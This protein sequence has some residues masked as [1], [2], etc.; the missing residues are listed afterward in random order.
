MGY[1]FLNPAIQGF[2][3]RKPPILVYT[4]HGRA[5]QPLALEWA[6]PQRPGVPLLPAPP[7][8]FDPA[9]HYRDGTFVVAVTPDRC[10]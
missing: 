8:A 5:W 6:F 3:V 1:H 10:P 9:C 7:T 2:D 4:C